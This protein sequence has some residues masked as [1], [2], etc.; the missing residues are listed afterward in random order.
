MRPSLAFQNSS[1]S[2]AHNF[3]LFYSVAGGN[4]YAQPSGSCPWP[5]TRLRLNLSFGSLACSAAWT[6][7]PGIIVQP[8]L[9]LLRL[10]DT[11]YRCLTANISTSTCSASTQNCGVILTPCPIKPNVTVN[12]G[13]PRSNTLSTV[14]EFVRPVA[15]NPRGWL[16]EVAYQNCLTGIST[17]SSLLF[18]PCNRTDQRQLFLFQW[19]TKVVRWGTTGQCLLT[20]VSGLNNRP[21]PL[22]SCSSRVAKFDFLFYCK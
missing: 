18:A 19:D 2:L 14:F 9:F 3:F 7:D 22:G 4:L 17:T 20:P 12:S 16:R 5:S 1:G 15:T 10:A 6:A 21:L 8:E 11:R 13:V